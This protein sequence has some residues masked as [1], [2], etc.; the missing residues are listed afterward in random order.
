[1]MRY[2]THP[3]DVWKHKPL[4]SLTESPA[5]EENGALGATPW[6]M[7]SKLSIQEVKSVEADI[8]QSQLTFSLRADRIE[9]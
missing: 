2:D 8:K 9:F 1:M 6:I 7:Y 4:N 3:G 5:T